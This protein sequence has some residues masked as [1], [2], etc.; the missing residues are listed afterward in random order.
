VITCSGGA[1][2][3]Y[4]FTYTTGTLTVNALPL[5]ITAEAKSKTYGEAD[6]ALTYTFAPAL[7]GS[8]SFSGGLSR[9]SGENVGAYAITQGTLAL[10]ANYNL[11]YVGANLT[12]NKETLTVTADDQ[13]MLGNQPDPAF[14][15][16]YSG[17]QYAETSAVIDTAP[18][19][20]V[21]GAH[22]T[23]STYAITCS[24]GVDNNYDFTYVAGTLTVAP[25]LVVSYNSVAAQ[26]GWVLESGETA[27]R[28]GAINN[29]STTFRVGDDAS[30]R[31][32][33][34]ILSFDVSSLPADAVIT[35]V[36]LKI[37]YLGKTGTNP[38]T[39][40][41]RLQVDLK[42]GV[43]STTN[44]LQKA[45]FQAAATLNAAGFVGKTPVSTGPNVHAAVLTQ[46]ALNKLNAAVGLTQ[47]QL[48][49]RFQ[50]DD[51]D[52]FGADFLKFYSGDATDI[53]AQPVLIIEYYIP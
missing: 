5:T 10:N 15:F 17:F 41:K 33:R 11:S 21:S 16:S 2:D 40:H 6:P 1:D 3:K 42:A 19:C 48:R 26:D 9:T 31:Q 12:I 51:N 36:T 23:P 38:F 49:L 53:N 46:T 13:S 28:G 29:L 44:V 4:E 43:F 8:D 35:K 45:D 30:N 27:S 39:T 52:D 47:M 20:G 37:T 25:P 14:T 34:S 24:G 7:V 32:Y 50:M 18:T 22:T